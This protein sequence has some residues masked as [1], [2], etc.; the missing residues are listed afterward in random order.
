VETR[1]PATTPKAS[2]VFMVDE[3]RCSRRS[4]KTCNSDDDDSRVVRKLTGW[5]RGVVTMITRA[6]LV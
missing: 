3:K 4:C 2:T 5:E 6:I 1:V